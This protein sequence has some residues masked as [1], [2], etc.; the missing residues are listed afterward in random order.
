[1]TPNGPAIKGVSVAERVKAGAEFPHRVRVPAPA[2]AE[3][4]KIALWAI[5]VKEP[6]CRV[7]RSMAWFLPSSCKFYKL[8]GCRGT[9]FFGSRSPIPLHEFDC[10]QRRRH[11]DVTFYC[12]FLRAGTVCKNRD[13]TYNLYCP[14]RVFVFLNFINLF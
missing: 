13:K 8:Y 11:G 4:L 7:E 2:R 9:R 10:E 6:V 14:R 1:M 3:C 5:L 12:V